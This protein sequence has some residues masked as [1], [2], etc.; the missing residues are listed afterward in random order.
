L[1]EEQIE[2]WY[3]SQ[4]DK[5]TLTDFLCEKYVLRNEDKSMKY[6]LFIQFVTLIFK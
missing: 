5:T 4:R 6:F 2:E 1:Y 3:N